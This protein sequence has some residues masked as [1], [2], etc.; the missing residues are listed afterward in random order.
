MLFR[1]V[2]QSRYSAAEIKRLMAQFKEEADDLNIT[3]SD[4]ALEAAIKRF[5]GLKD[6][7]R[8]T[9]KDLR[10]YTLAKLLKIT[11]SSPGAEVP[12]EEEEEETG[13]KTPS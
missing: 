5:E 2:S 8:I 10:K 4:Q 3:I 12:G 11:S 9:E 6:S 1:S 13:T 7:P